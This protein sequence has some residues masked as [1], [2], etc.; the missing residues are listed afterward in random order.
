MLPGRL[1]QRL[2]SFAIHSIRRR[3][4]Q[5][6]HRADQVLGPLAD[7]PLDLRAGDRRAPQRGQHAGQRGL[8]IAQRIDQRAVE[9]DHARAHAAKWLARHSLGGHG[10]A[11]T[12]V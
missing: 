7:Q 11:F 3:L 10:A 2:V 12:W 9:I 5:R 1:L 8:E 6:Q 4:C